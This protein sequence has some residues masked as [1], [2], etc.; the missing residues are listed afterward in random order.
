MIA[1]WRTVDLFLLL[2]FSL[3]VVSNSSWPH[4]LEHTGFPVL[5]YLPEFVHT[6]HWVHDAIQPS[7]PLSLLL[8]LS[9]IFPSIR[10]FTNELALHVRWSKYWSFSSAS[11]LPM[12][13]QGWFPLRLTGWSCSPTDSQKSS[14]ASQF[15]STD[16]SVLSLLYGP[17]LTSIHDYWQNHSFDSVQSC[18]TLCD[19]MDWSTPGFP[20]HHQLLELA[21]THIHWVGDPI[22]HLILCCPLLLLPS[23]FPRI[24]VFPNESVL[25]IRWPEYWTFSFSISPSNEYSGFISFRID[26]FDLLAVQ[27]TLKSL[28]QHH[29]SK[30]SIL[31]HSAFYMVQLSHPYMTTRK[32]IALKIQT[33]VG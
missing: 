17:T 26:W 30:P 11:V 33:F 8:L 6:V 5:H 24:R 21:Q 23:V 13:I 28:L 4:G 12:N 22:Q 29:S 2:L 3:S 32:T 15:E 7:H 27:G 25:C 9:S 14:P 10:A 19:T 31:Q 18:P 20:V 16:S 1:Q